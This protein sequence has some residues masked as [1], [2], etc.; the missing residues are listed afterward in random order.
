[1]KVSELDTGSIH[2]LHR[3]IREALDRDDEAAEGGSLPFGVRLHS[4]LIRWGDIL[5]DELARRNERFV[6]IA[7]TR[8]G[9]LPDHDQV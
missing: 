1:V 5:E 7:W 3:L 9:R 6:P 2:L 8:S 4:G